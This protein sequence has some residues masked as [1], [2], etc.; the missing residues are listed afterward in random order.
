MLTVDQKIK[1]F[2]SFNELKK[3]LRKDQ[4]RVDYSYPNTKKKQQNVICQLDLRTG[5]GYVCGRFLEISNQYKLDSRGWINIKHFNESE[6]RKVIEE[7][8]MSLSM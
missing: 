4:F 2:D 5:N 6:L 3:K 7:S 1:L 8:I